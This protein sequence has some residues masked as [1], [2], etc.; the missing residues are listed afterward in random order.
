MLDQRLEWSINPYEVGTLSRDIQ[1]VL[2]QEKTQKELF[3]CYS[4]L[5]KWL[6]GGTGFS[7][8]VSSY[9]SRYLGSF[10]KWFVFFCRSYSWA[11]M[12]HIFSFLKKSSG[13]D[14]S[15][16]KPP[17]SVLGLIGLK[18]KKPVSKHSNLTT[19]GLF[20]LRASKDFHFLCETA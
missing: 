16:K 14:G 20:I 4:L 9:K 17:L 5:R 1:S 12:T 7:T 19:E 18:A 15:R 11:F 6:E 2:L 3:H 8:C 13:W 10:W